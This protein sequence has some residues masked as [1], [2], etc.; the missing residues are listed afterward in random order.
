[1]IFGSKDGFV[2]FIAR[3]L[4]SYTFREMNMHSVNGAYICRT[5]YPMTV[6]KQSLTL[7]FEV[8]MAVGLTMKTAVS[9]NVKLCSTVGVYRRFRTPAP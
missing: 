5:F 3:R 7:R 9:L 2:E 8:L 4:Q 1:M 6:F